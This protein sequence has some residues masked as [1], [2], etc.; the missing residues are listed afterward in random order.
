MHLASRDVAGFEAF[1]RGPVGT[2]LE[3]PAALIAEARAAGRLGEL[4]WLCRA[5][6]LQ[7]AARSGL[8]SDVT[9]FLNV[10]PAGLEADCPEHL[11]PALDQA[12]AT[13]RVVLEISERDSAQD[14]T[15]LL[16][17]TDRA[18][19][20]AWGVALDDVGSDAVSLALLPF[21][22]PEIVKLDMTLLK[23]APLSTAAE[24]GAAVRAYSERTGATILA[25]CVETEEQAEQAAVF[26]ATYGQGY[27]FG[28][29]APLPASLPVP[30]HPLHLHALP[31][32]LAGA[33]PFEV[34]H[35]AVESQHARLDYLA[36]VSMRLRSHAQNSFESSVALALFDSQDRYERHTQVWEEIAE[37]N[38]LSVCLVPGM[39]GRRSLFRQLVTAPAEGSRLHGE[40]ALVVVTPQY[41]GAIVMRPSDRVAADGTALVEYIYSQDRTLVIAAGRAFLEHVQSPTPGSEQAL[42]GR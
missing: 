7:A 22:Q 6:S 16:H 41:A 3:S 32:P 36:P 21:I 42:S 8:P 25:E 34:L 9:W 10:E 30:A 19:R 26:G 15:R 29:P 40:Y 20:H 28:A 13:L 2:A 35:N 38:C 23:A 24:I 18:R 27:L 1:S 31:Q 33:T 4:D 39:T 5:S 37:R 14:V 17:A 11:R 12:R